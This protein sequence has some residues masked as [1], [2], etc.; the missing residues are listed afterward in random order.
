MSNFKISDKFDAIIKEILFDTLPSSFVEDF[1]KLKS[2]NSCY[3][4]I[5][6]IGSA[7]DLYDNDEFKI[8]ASEI[9]N[10]GG[11][12]FAYKHGYF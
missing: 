7:V 12:L 8:L 2:K 4:E 6:K 3:L 10:K 11:K 9:V 1:Q 5:K